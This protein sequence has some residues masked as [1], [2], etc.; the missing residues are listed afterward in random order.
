MA[1]R[2]SMLTWVVPDSSGGVFFQPYANV[3]SNHDAMVLTFNDSNAR[4]GCHGRFT[5]PQDYS[6]AANL[7]ITWSSS[8]TAN[9]VEWDFD[10]RAF[11]GN[12]TESFNQAQDQEQLNQ[13]DTAPSAA[14]ERMEIS[15]AL[16]DS[17][18]AAGDNVL[19]TIFRDS[20]DAG[21]TLA[22]AVH[23]FELEFEYT[24]A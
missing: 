19:F 6:S 17:N 23:I 15:I 24:A 5:V 2:I 8:G 7:I 4:E 1:R 10:Y 18:F 3:G 22:A 12:D 9:D 14:H 21:D 11:G 16:T 20:A 13:N